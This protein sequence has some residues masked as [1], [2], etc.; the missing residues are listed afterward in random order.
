[1][2][3]V[4]NMEIIKYILL[5]IIFS[6]S[7][8]IG[9]IISKMYENRVTEL[10]EFKNMLNIIKTKI[11][12]TYEPLGEIFEQIAQRQETNIEKIF[13][14]MAVQIQFI[15]VND[16]WCKTIQDADISINQED[17]DILK[18]LGKLLGQTDVEGQV[19]EIEVTE[20]FLDMQISKAEEDKK[21]NQKMYKTLG[22]V[23]GLVIVIILI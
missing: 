21:K 11:K 17:K 4:N 18:K 3:K 20:Q 10:K 14:K 23:A 8:G 13:G 15:K 7:T 16:A 9:L 6:A 22:I 2:S 5:I 12:F 1:M 19:S